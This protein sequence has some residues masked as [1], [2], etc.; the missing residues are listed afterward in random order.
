MSVKVAMEFEE[1]AKAPCKG[2]LH[3]FFKM[4]I[5]ARKKQTNPIASSI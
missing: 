3:T 1:L 4:T 5:E 2:N